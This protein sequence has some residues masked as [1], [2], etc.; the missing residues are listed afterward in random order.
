M[1]LVERPAKPT[2]VNIPSRQ[3]ADPIRLSQ[4]ESPYPATSFK[5]RRVSVDDVSPDK[6]FRRSA[7][8]ILFPALRPCASPP[9]ALAAGSE[10]HGLLGQLP[11]GPDRSPSERTRRSERYVPVKNQHGG[12]GDK[13]Y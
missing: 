4:S 11:G 3:V 12:V 13:P 9:T 5:F 8:P 1:I 6:D 2:S 10:R 7:M